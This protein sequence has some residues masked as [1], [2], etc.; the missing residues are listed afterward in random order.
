[1]RR[2]IN[3]RGLTLIEVAI[4]A[5]TIAVISAIAIPRFGKV[6]T[7]LKMKAAG[8]DIIS[9]LRLA[10]SYAVSQKKPFGV[11]FDTDNNQFMLFRDKVNLSSQTYDDGDSTMKTFTLP[12][13][14]DFSYTSFSNDVVIFRPNGSASS[15]GSVDLYPQAQEIYDYMMIDVLAS[16]GRVKMY[17]GGDYD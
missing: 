11:Y 17:K 9:Q 10:R 15:T 14:I 7:K 13:D 5:V 12:G 16:T 6:M 1:M 4:V 3:E 2:L 8:R